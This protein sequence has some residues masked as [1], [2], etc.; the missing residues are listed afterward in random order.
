M[1]RHSKCVQACLQ[2]LRCDGTKKASVEDVTEWED[3]E[4]CPS[5]HDRPLDL[6]LLAEGFFFLDEESDSDSDS[7][8]VDEEIKED[9]LKEIQT[10]A[11]LRHFNS[12]L[13]EAQAVAFQA[14]KE[15]ADSKT[16]WKR[17]YTGNS[18]CTIRHYAL[19]H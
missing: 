3:A 10:E 17:H 1:G 13:T 14:E 2:N 7:E 19:K 4:Y 9:E 11:Q 5:D 16:K 18:A 15:M 8:F 12:I 6:D